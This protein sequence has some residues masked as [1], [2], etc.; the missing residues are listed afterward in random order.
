MSAEIDREKTKIIAEWRQRAADDLES[1]A[2]ILRETDNY[3]ISVYHAHQ[4]VEK[5]LKA[6]LMTC[7]KTFRFIHDLNALLD[8]VL[9]DRAD[10]GITEK[11]SF[12]NSLYPR[13]RYPT[14]DEVSKLQAEKCLDIAKDVFSRFNERKNGR[15][16]KRKN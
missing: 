5:L 7:G 2:V 10:E 16:E 3:E 8:Q 11:V 1:A 13:L 12:L 15:T 6:E 14:G 4:A 9:E